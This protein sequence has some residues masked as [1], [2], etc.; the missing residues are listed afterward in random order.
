M[1]KKLSIYVHI[2]FCK[3]KCLY[4]DF[5]S[6]PASIQEQEVYIKALVREIEKEAPKYKNYI[7]DTIFFGGGTPSLLDPKQV[8]LLMKAL[9]DNYRVEKNA[10]ITIECNPATADFEKLSYF[11]KKGI[12]RISIGLQTA[13]NKQLKCLGRIH[14][15]EEFLD[16]YENARTAGF[17]NINVDIM[18]AIPGQD[19]ESCMDTVVKV[20]ELGPEHIS[21]YSLIVE[22]ETPFFAMDLELPTEEE[23]REMYY[24]TRR[25]L[26]NQ[27]YGQYEISNYAKEGYACKHNI[28]YWTGKDYA[29]FG[30]GAA[31]C[32]KGIRFTNISDREMYV[33][34]LLE[35][36]PV[37]EIRSEVQK[38]T[39]EEQM[40]EFMFLGLRMIRGVS[41]EDFKKRFGVTLKSKY[42]KVLE[43]HMKDYLISYQD[44]R[45]ALTP[46]GIDVSNY[47]MADYLF[48]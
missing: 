32:V 44:K 16:T 6:A 47:V 4:C 27:G 31:S 3:Q 33:K 37:D 46:R 14:S 18:Q 23:E 35:D 22:E 21:A 40:E 5:L 13:D 12:N 8:S 25:Y 19:I 45:Y 43:Q 1:E 24:A 30:I 10:E 7:V 39:K 41:E 20:V 17:E 34:N 48:D 29:G 26:T 2:P 38:L 9:K 28:A 36:K 42:E 15:F 11:R